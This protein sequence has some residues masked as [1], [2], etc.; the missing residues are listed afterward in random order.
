MKKKIMA[1]LLVGSAVVGAS[2]APLSAQAVTT[3]NTP[4]TVGVEGGVLPDQDIDTIEVDPDPNAPNTDFDLIA[5]PKS[6]NF[7]P[8]KIGEDLSDIQ[9]LSSERGKRVLVG[10]LRGTKEGWHVTGEISGMTNGTEQLEGTIRLAPRTVY[11]RYTISAGM[12]YYLTES[13]Q[14][15]IDIAND[16]V[17]P[18]SNETN[19]KL[20]GGA[21]TLMS[22]AVGKGQGTWGG[23]IRDAS[24]SVTTPYQQLKKGAY[25]GNITWN[26]V[27]G[28]SI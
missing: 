2:L 13:S 4:V 12:G 3:G 9:L 1:S 11:A 19:L 21:S 22:A 17:A 28:P 16:P 25:T 6:L 8:V 20:G 7:S 26:L 24:L 5:I 18:T 15:G 23:Q 27:A 10:D 14:N